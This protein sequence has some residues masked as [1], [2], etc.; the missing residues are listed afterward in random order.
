MSD[1][2]ETPSAERHTPG[3]WRVE[4]QRYPSTANFAIQTELPCINGLSA[5]CTLASCFLPDE[6]EVGYTDGALSA[7]SAEANARLIAAAPDLLAALRGLL[8]AGNYA[9][10]QDARRENA[11]LASHVQAAW[12]AIAK[13]E[14]R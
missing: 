4:R 14:G 6:A 7:E 11:V 9:T 8:E 3:P 12:D 13:T 5:W 2:S 10:P 1:R